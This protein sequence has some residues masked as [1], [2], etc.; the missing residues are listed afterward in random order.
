MKE[1]E[2]AGWRKAAEKKKAEKASAPADL[3]ARL[4][5]VEKKV[6]IKDEPKKD[7]EEKWKN[8]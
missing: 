4:E 5:A 3:V 7:E 6:G 2:G 1:L 8:K